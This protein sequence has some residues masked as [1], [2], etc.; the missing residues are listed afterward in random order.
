MFR[1]LA[2]RRR[3]GEAP[4]SLETIPSKTLSRKASTWTF[5]RVGTYSF[6][7]SGCIGWEFLLEI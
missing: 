3:S 7:V 6:S 1:A 4:V 2:L 5:M